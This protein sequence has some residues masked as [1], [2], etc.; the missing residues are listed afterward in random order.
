MNF[1]HKSRSLFM[2]MIMF[3]ESGS[4]IMKLKE[5]HNEKKSRAVDVQP[6]PRIQ[7]RLGP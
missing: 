2:Q 7:D 3:D 1:Y 6:M 4:W 5:Y